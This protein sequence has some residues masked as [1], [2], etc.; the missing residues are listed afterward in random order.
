M[1]AKIIAVLTPNHI[2]E[3]S[4]PCRRALQLATILALFGMGLSTVMLINNAAFPV[5]E[6]GPAFQ[7]VSIIGSL[8]FLALASSSYGLLMLGQPNLARPMI[9]AYAVGMVAM[10]AYALG[11]PAGVDLIGAICLVFLPALIY[12]PAEL[13]QRWTAVGVTVLAVIGVQ[14]WLLNMTPVFT[15]PPDEVDILK[16]NVVLVAVV[17]GF[18]VIYLHQ[19]AEAAKAAVAAEKERAD[20][21]LR[22]IMPESVVD[23]L[24]SGDSLLADRHEDAC[25]LFADL[26]GFTRMS[27]GRPAAEIVTVLNH[28]FS[29]FDELCD[30]Y[31][32]EKIKTIGDGYLAVTG[33]PGRPESGDAAAALADYALAMRQAMIEMGED[34]D[35][36]ISIRIGLHCGPAISG[37][38]GKRKYAFDVW[39][40]TVNFASRM[41][42]N[43]EPGVITISK[44]FR[45]R[46][47]DAFKTESRGVV[48]AKGVGEVEVFA[49][50]S[51]SESRAAAA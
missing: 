30:D 31:G 42:S 27:V 28:L 51:R 44:E 16:F 38:I 15:L 6:A 43:S 39:G 36:P 10:F 35:E 17:L 19:T 48:T 13:K 25:V 46:L 21:L 8:V 14:L 37:V 5:A 1:P 41:E 34:L 33:L 24:K 45:A 29:R 4:E 40:A 50:T 18:F 32:V 26:V 20:D 47:G 7:R 22:N 3:R 9:L 12:S 23:R 49:L 2:A 11:R